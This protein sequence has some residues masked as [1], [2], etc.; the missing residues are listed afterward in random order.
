MLWRA[1]REEAFEYIPVASRAPYRLA[2]AG[3]LERGKTAG[4]S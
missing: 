4:R 2:E 3:L 1:E